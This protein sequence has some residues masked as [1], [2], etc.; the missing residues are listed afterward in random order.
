MGFHSPG[1]PKELTTELAEAFKERLLIRPNPYWVDATGA[2]GRLLPV[3]PRYERQESLLEQL[4]GWAIRPPIQNRW[5]GMLDYGDTLSWHRNQDDDQWYPEYDWHPVG[6]WGWYNCEGSGTHTGALLQFARSGN[7]QYF[8]FGENLARHIMDVDTIHYDTIANDPRLKNLLDKSYSQVGSMHRHNAD[9][10]GG[11]SDE[12]SHT[13]VWGLILYHYITGD[14][15][16]RDVAL[17]V[18]EFFLSEP[19]TYAKHPDVAPARALANTLWG[20]VLLYE[21]TGEEKFKNGA[22]K[23]IE[24]FLKGQQADGSF[25]ENYNPMDGSDLPG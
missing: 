7:W 8:E 20:D 1:S 3:D 25:L 23:I 17:E 2:L 14:E 12:A 10:W 19:F 5:Y 15:R 21:L 13:N 4:F 16:A 6:R 11:R 9:H 22:D 18:G 24:V